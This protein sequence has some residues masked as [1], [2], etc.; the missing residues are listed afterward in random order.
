MEAEALNRKAMLAGVAI[1][2]VTAVAILTRTGA[3]PGQPSESSPALEDTAMVRRSSA[4][5]YPD[6]TPDLHSVSVTDIPGEPTP[7]WLFDEALA[8]QKVQE[9]TGTS[10]WVSYVARRTTAMQIEYLLFAQ[11]EPLPTLEEDRSEPQWIVA[12]ETSELMSQG[13]IERAL[14]FLAYQEDDS[15]LVGNRALLV[16]NEGAHPVTV[17]FLNEHDSDGTIREFS[18]SFQDIRDLPGVPGSISR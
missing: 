5:I 11:S 17:R 12:W 14:S 2:V 1:I 9:L 7:Y 8:V 13:Q 18:P 10:A 16:L 6:D 3:R 15:A 4:I